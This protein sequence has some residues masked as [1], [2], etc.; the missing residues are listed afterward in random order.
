MDVS[1]TP[2]RIILMPTQEQKGEDLDL[3]DINE[4]VDEILAQTPRD[5]Q[6]VYLLHMAK[7]AL[8]ILIESNSWLLLHDPDVYTLIMAR[9]A[10]EILGPV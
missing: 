8:F 1:T 5:Q 2:T 7:E 3:A 4:W 6:S 10:D 9:M